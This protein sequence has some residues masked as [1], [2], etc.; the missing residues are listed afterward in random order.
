[1]ILTEQQ[2]KALYN[3]YKRIENPSLTYLQF[4]RSAHGCDFDPKQD[5]RF[6]TVMVRFAGMWLGIEQDGYTHS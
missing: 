3:V 2:R 5:Y 4:R 6:G 1:M